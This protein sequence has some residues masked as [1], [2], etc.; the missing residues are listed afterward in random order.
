MSLKRK[1]S[2]RVVDMHAFSRMTEQERTQVVLDGLVTADNVGF[3]RNAL[4]D[5]DVDL[6]RYLLSRGA[7]IQAVEDGLVAANDVYLWHAALVNGE[8]DLVKYL[9]RRGADVNQWGL[10]SV[11]PVH[12]AFEFNRD[13]AVLR[14]L[15]EAKA[16]TNV[17]YPR[18][19]LHS[20]VTGDNHG[21]LPLLSTIPFRHMLHEEDCNGG[22]PMD[23]MAS[24]LLPHFPTSPLI[25][26][27][28]K[29]SADWK[30]ELS[31]ALCAYVPVSALAS[32]IVAYLT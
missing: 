3:W 22:T 9:F 7:G 20:L 15:L 31:A 5:S 21:A 6:A 19:I 14:F 24:E 28:Q 2:N 10:R 12:W 23:L 8:M 1:H 26:F 29:E 18:N 30:R 13:G 27:L 25:G 17:L 4:V 32:M 11:R 16:D